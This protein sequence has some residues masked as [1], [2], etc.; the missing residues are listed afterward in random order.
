MAYSIGIW[1][2]RH[3]TNIV[4]YRWESDRGGQS[5]A[6]FVV[7]DLREQSVC[8]STPEGQPL[9]DMT[10]TARVGRCEGLTPDVDT[11]LFIQIASSILRRIDTDGAPPRTAHRV[12]G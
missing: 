7:L 9:G 3:S 2:T 4:V 5:R 8:P 12:Y 6:G 1:M 10:L 11:G